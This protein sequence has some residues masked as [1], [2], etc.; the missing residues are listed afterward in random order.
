MVKDN[1][2]NSLI[3]DVESSTSFRQGEDADLREA[4][5]LE[6]QRLRDRLANYF[7][8][9]MQIGRGK[10]SMLFPV[11]EPAPVEYMMV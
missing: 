6:K 1:E 11:E 9:N 10:L 7:C 3:N 8:G 2:D 4:R 5:N